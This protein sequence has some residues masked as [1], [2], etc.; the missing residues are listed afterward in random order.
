MA[1]ADQNSN[2]IT[3]RLLRSWVRCTRK[4]WLDSYG[5]D[6]Q[7]LWT[8]HRALQL[9]HQ[10]RSL[11]EL[12]P[13]KAGKGIQACEK[14]CVGVMG[15]R[16]KGIGPKGTFLEAHPPLLQRIEG[17]SRWGKYT[18]RPVIVRQGRKLTREHRL[19]LSLSG[20]LLEK[21]Q[22]APVHEGLVVCKVS[23]GLEI[24]QL[25]LYGR[26]REKLIEALNKLNANLKE[27]EIPP[28]TSDRRKCTLC[29]WRSLCNHEASIQGDLSEVSGIGPRRKQILHEIGIHN[30]Q[31][32]ANTNPIDLRNKLQQYGEQHS[33]IAKQLVAQA[34]TQKN[35]SSE[36]FNRHPAFPELKNA[37]GILIYD[38]ESDPDARDDF[39]HG[40]IHLNHNKNGI[41]ELNKAK[42][43][44]MLA[45]S[46]H[47]KYAC[48]RRLK[49]K[50][51]LYKD[52]PIMH[53]G[54]TEA[55]NLL[56]L[57]KL[58]GANEEELINLR[59]RLIDVHARL[60]D[61]WRLPV[62][63]YSLKTVANWVGFQ[64]QQQGVD[65]ARALLWW[66]QWQRS[67]HRTKSNINALRLL[68]QYNQ[69]DCLATWAVA[70]W[71]LKQDSFVL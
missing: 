56:R 34:S 43:H 18:Y 53:Y 30:L 49:Q 48:W 6:K 36:R 51:M 3:D 28:L 4:A 32:L 2:V 70:A 9:D 20:L 60:K 54:E 46:E 44:P 50:L 64:W 45:L 68:F 7:R 65:G 27:T 26:P 12:S 25:Y 37:P 39:L 31:A 23:T 59:N 22:K 10:Q 33:E 15:I 47:G 29:S 5:N 55:I 19:S 57:A 67:G 17:E 61:L 66:R 8:A 11:W 58:Q 41:W 38:I 52:W 71:L 13:I 21:L 63:S 42:Y 69:D 16:L 24:Q 62:N 40:F 35:G 14:G 1:I